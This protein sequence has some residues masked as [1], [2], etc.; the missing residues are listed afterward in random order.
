MWA[1]RKKIPKSMADRRLETEMARVENE[2]VEMRLDTKGLEVT[3]RVQQKR[4]LENT[5]RVLTQE[6]QALLR[7]KKRVAKIQ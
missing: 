4:V 7:K 2:L 3:L 6:L 1:E 5:M